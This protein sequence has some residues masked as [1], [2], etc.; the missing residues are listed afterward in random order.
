MQAAFNPAVSGTN[1]GPSTQKEVDATVCDANRCV[2]RMLG[3][4]LL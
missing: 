4:N 3:T 2:T 1:W